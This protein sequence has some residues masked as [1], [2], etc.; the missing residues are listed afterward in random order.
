MEERSL[1]LSRQYL[2]LLFA[3]AV[4]GFEHFPSTII[5]PINL[6]IFGG[7]A[8]GGGGGGRRVDGTGGGGGCVDGG[9]GGNVC[10]R[11]APTKELI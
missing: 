11:A 6:A 10:G 3:H 9:E 4:T 7:A 1:L 2:L 8:N 5:C